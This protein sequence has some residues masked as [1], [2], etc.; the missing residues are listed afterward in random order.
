MSY[1]IDRERGRKVKSTEFMELLPKMMDIHERLVS[2]ETENALL[3]KELE[4]CRQRYTALLGAYT[5]ARREDPN[6]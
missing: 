3:K 6:A 5:A 4:D 1:N 2:A